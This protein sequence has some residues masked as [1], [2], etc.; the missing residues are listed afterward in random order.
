LKLRASD[1]AAAMTT[2]EELRDLTLREV[3][4]FKASDRALRILAH[5]VSAAG[6]Q[7]KNITAEPGTMTP[8]QAG[9]F[10]SAVIQAVI[11]AGSLDR[12]RTQD[13]MRAVYKLL[14]GAVPAWL[15]EPEAPTRN[16]LKAMADSEAKVPAPEIE[17]DVDP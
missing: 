11:Q 15:Q 6:E 10:C 14:G 8:Q 4:E 9:G 7:R 12:S 16:R 5:K 3:G 1:Y 17:L 2:A 13:V